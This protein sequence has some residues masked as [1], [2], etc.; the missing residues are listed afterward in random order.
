MRGPRMYKHKVYSVR[1]AILAP[2]G[3]EREKKARA[4]A[5]ACVLQKSVQQQA[6]QVCMARTA[7]T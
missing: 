4:A 6:K 7:N 2:L 1:D 5:T 3:A